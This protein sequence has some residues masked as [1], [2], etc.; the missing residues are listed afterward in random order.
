MSQLGPEGAQTLVGMQMCGQMASKET[1]GMFPAQ[2]R[3]E[4]RDQA[5]AAGS[6]R[7]QQAP[8][9]PGAGTN[10]SLPRGSV[11]TRCLVALAQTSGSGKDA[12]YFTKLAAI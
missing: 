6:C 11:G 3:T 10:R 12:S 9:R 2:P 1:P 7:N 5:G 4:D 8:P